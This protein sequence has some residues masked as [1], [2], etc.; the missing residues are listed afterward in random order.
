MKHPA[1]KCLEF[2]AIH[3][4]AFGHG[5]VVADV[6]VYVVDWQEF[7]KEAQ[8]S[9]QQ[10]LDRLAGPSSNSREAAHEQQQELQNERIQRQLEQDKRFPRA[11]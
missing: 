4:W 11:R 10:L 3:S 8:Q 5:Q 9:L 7:L 1:S 2:I 6:E